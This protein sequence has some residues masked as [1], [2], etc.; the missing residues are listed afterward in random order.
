MWPALEAMGRKYPRALA[1]QLGSPDTAIAYGAARLS[2][3]TR[4]V[5]AKDELVRLFKKSDAAGRRITIEALAA[6]GDAGALSAVQEAL[7]DADRDV[8]ITA[9]RAL[10][11]ANSNAA[12]ERLRAAIASK[13]LREADLTEKIAFFEAYG[14]IAVQEDLERLDRLLNGRKLLGRESPEMR[15]C[16]AMALGRIA[17]PEARTI[18]MKA[19]DEQHPLIRNA[20]N[21]ALE[22]PRRYR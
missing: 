19:A 15:S 8:R 17:L 5:E 4:L 21:K 6:I 2:G 1:S 3:Q 22:A 11:N 10:G 14:A 7:D 16:A 12:R 18:L 13:G 9:A 20:V